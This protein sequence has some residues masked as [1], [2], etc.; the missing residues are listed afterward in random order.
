MKKAELKKEE[1]RKK[2]ARK[3]KRKKE[4]KKAVGKWAAFFFSKT[5]NMRK[6]KIFFRSKV[7]FFQAP[8]N[9]LTA[10]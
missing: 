8:S 3:R 9:W 5:K 10:L 2:E 7:R 6:S 1:K 4:E